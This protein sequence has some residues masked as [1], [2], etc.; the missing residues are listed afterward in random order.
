M[1]IV[2]KSVKQYT[3]V[4]ALKVMI[5]S[6]TGH[7]GIFGAIKYTCMPWYFIVIILPY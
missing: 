1:F 4:E 6:A 2:Y 7:T 5:Y 3:S